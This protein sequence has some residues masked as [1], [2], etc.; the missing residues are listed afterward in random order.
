MAHST[1]KSPVDST[2]QPIAPSDKNLSYPMGTVKS[3]AYTPSY[4]SQ[5]PHPP[6]LDRTRVGGGGEKRVGRERGAVRGRGGGGGEIR[7]L[8]AWA[9]DLGGGD[10]GGGREVERRNWEH[11]LSMNLSKLR[12]TKAAIFWEYFFGIL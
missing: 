2:H 4:I 11:L 9:A 12:E 5:P 6:P 3:R 1:P 7:A 8:L 10:I